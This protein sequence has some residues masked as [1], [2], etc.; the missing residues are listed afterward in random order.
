MG[1]LVFVLLLSTIKAVM[2]WLLAARKIPLANFFAESDA[3]SDAAGLA[4]IIAPIVLFVK[5]LPQI[6][7]VIAGIFKH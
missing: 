2:R 4:L 5:Y 3:Y 1:E 6:S 7:G